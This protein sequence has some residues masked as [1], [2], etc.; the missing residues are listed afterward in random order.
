MGLLA[1][2][3]VWRASA[4][5]LARLGARDVAAVNRRAVERT[6][7]LH[8]R[9]ARRQRG[10][11][12]QP[13]II[14]GDIGPRGDGYAVS[15]PSRSA[16]RYDYHAP[17]VEVLARAGRRPAAAA[18]HDQPARDGRHRARRR[19]RRAA[20]AGVAD[21]RA[22]RH[23]PRRHAAGRLRR[24]GRRADL[25]LPASASWSTAFTRAT[26]APVLR[27]AAERGAPWLT[28]F[29][30]MRANAST[31]THAELDNSTALDRGD[32]AAL[33]RGVGRSA[34]RS[35]ARRSWAVAAGRTPS[36]W[37]ASRPRRCRSDG[38]HA[39]AVLL[40][41]AGAA[42][43]G[44]RRARA[45]GVRSARVRD[46]GVR[47]AGGAGAA[48]PRQAHLARARRATCR[49]TTRRRSTCC[50]RRWGPN[51]RPTSC[52][53]S[54]MAPFFYLPHTLF[55]AEHGLDHFDAVDAR[56]IRADQ[57]L[58]RRVEH[59]ARTSRAIRSARSPSSAAGRRTATPTSAAWCPRA[60]ACGCRGRRASP[61]WT[62][63]RSGCWSC[64]S[65]SRTTRRRWCAGASRTTS[66]TSA[67]C[68]PICC[69]APAPAG[70][71]GPPPNAARWSSTRCA[72]R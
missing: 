37:R 17:Q 51:T 30:G 58:Q 67:S 41:G 61:G 35:P 64:W 21:D 13:V 34:A 11:A 9:M 68:I 44:R 57:A 56:A 53:A 60:R 8:R 6:R 12:R 10:G 54:G 22:R 28:R 2:C 29:R 26:S 47:G 31:K 3:L 5:Y 62:R 4:D 33:G 19:A 25:R 43:G 63:T 36:T 49:P 46:P 18:D 23:A 48:R 72:A 27:A 71:T 7:A 50:W 59:P 55:V 69:G 65:C 45:S 40:A 66:T 39:Q 38:R 42:A 32:P 24:R 14:T 1:G 70:W 20:G 15:G 52:W 16:R